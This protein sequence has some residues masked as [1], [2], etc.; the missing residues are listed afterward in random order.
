[1]SESRTSFG[2]KGDGRV[3]QADITTEKRYGYCIQNSKRC[4]NVGGVKGEKEQELKS[5]ADIENGLEDMGR[6]KSKLG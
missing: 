6:G 3:F 1:M 5:P 2:W 4:L